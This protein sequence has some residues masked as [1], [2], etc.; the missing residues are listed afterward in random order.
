MLPKSL[1]PACSN[2]LT[3]ASKLSVAFRTSPRSV[4]I[5]PK[6]AWMVPNDFKNAISAINFG[7]PVVLRAPRA[8]ISTSLCGL[9]N[10]L[11]QVKL[12]NAA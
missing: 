8:E 2:D 11:T 3:A 5:L 6:I 12:A 1:L 10:M 4:W 7:E 9:A